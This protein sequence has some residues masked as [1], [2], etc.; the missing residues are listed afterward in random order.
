MWTEEFGGQ[1][2]ES[3]IFQ[4]EPV[5][6]NRRRVRGRNLQG[7]GEE[8]LWSVEQRECWTIGDWPLTNNPHQ[9]DIR[10]QESVE[11]KDNCE[12]V[13]RTIASE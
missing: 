7:L 4:H 1:G 10:P 12:Y 2:K 3:V 5:A 13:A 8:R 6:E 11:G 9:V